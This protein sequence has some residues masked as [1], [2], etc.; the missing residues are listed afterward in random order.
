MSKGKQ[1]VTI[2]ITADMV[3][4]GKT[5]VS[6]NLASIYAQYGKKTVLLGFD[7]RKPKIYQEFGLS[8]KAGL[9]SY[10]IN[11]ASLEEVIQP[12]GKIE[13]LDIILSGPVP[14]NP[15]ESHCFQ[16]KGCRF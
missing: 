13:H 16:K 2:M 14:P 3:S 4:V 9:S 1:K 15:T 11:K 10:L 5:Y 7:L 8:N 6:I 12:S